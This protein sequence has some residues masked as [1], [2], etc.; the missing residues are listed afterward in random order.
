MSVKINHRLGAHLYPLG[1]LGPGREHTIASVDI[2]IVGDVLYDT[3]IRSI[4]GDVVVELIAASGDLN[5]DTGL[6]K[7]PLHVG[8]QGVGPNFLPD[9]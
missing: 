3:A 5:L 7:H 8:E 1:D 6:E 9:V 4:D 2:G